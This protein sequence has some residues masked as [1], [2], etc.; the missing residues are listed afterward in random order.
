MTDYRSLPQISYSDLA[1]L[2]RAPEVFKHHVVDGNKRKATKAMDFGSYFHMMVL[3][4]DEVDKHYY[5]S[6]FDEMPTGKYA[7]FI[8]KQVELEQTGMLESE[9][10]EEAKKHADLRH[11][12]ETI[13]KTLTEGDTGEFYDK[14]KKDLIAGTGKQL[15]SKADK[16]KAEAM[17][18]SIRSHETAR[19]YLFEMRADDKRKVYTELEVMWVAESQMGASVEVKSKID[20]LIIN[21]EKKRV[22]ILDL[23][24]TRGDNKKDFTSSLFKYQY[25]VQLMFYI[26]AA[27]YYIQTEL[28]QGITQYTFDGLFVAVKS[29]QPYQTHCFGL[30]DELKTEGESR[31]KELLE[32]YLTRLKNNQWRPFE[33]YENDG[34]IT[35]S[36]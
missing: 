27:S 1:L 31:Y 26:A 16:A 24:S 29:D 22:L 7:D 15:I 19:K 21:T 9:I 36:I 8:Q 32:E 11:K 34:I 28:G 23:K 35:L 10:F 12:D 6:V 4:A 14:F 33:Y 3:E 17:R 18:E 13:V 20:R 2:A 5:V 30:D 25:Q